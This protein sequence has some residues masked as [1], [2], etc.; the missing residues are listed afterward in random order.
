MKSMLLLL[1]SLNAYAGSLAGVT[2]PDS[3]Q[4]GGKTLV[5]NGMGLREKYMLDVY[6]GGLYLPA[7]SSD[8]SAI[9]NMEAPKRVVMHF[10][11]DEVPKDKI[12]ETL[13]EGVAKYPEFAGLKPKMDQ[14]A[15]WM[16]D[17][18]E[19]DEM[20]YEYVPGEGTSVIVKGK[21]KGTIAGTDFMKLVFSIYLGPKPAN[22][23]LKA[24]MLGK[25]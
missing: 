5:L 22:E 1:L 21:K 24:G 17:L 8:A 15:G 7:K 11:Y 16:E 19:G 9:I 20:V 2:L 3:A 13:Y 6:V 23:A 18:V 12:T 10:I 4:L 25:G 14:F